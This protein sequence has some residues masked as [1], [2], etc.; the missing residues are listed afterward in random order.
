M[1]IL[2]EDTISTE[3]SARR[4]SALSS[5]FTL[6]DHIDNLTVCE[7]ISSVSTAEQLALLNDAPNVR[8]AEENHSTTLYGFESYNYFN[9]QWAFH[10]T[11]SYTYYINNLPIERTS[12]ADIDINLPEAYEALSGLDA[13]RSVTVAVIDTGV[14][15]TH[16]ALA[17]HI[18]TN[19]DEIPLNGIDDDANGYIDDIYGWDFYHNDN[20][21]CHYYV[22]DLGQIGALPEDNDNHG[23]HCAGIIAASQDIFGVA[24]GI[25]IRI[26][27]LKIHGGANASGS[28]SAAIKAIKYAETAGADICNM[29]W[30]TPLYSE[31]LETV[32]RESDMLFV[33]AAGNYGNNNN[34][35]PLYPSSFTL[36]NMISVAFVTQSGT[37]A[38]DS[39]Y[40][41]STVDI[42]APGQDIYSTTV[43]GLYH[44]LSG[45][46]MAAPVV[47]GTA[48]LLYAC[49]DS[50]YPQNVKEII[51]QT[52]KPL[53]SLNGYVRYPG[54]PDAAAALAA[55]DSLVS[56]TTAPTLQPVTSHAEESILVDLYPED[57]GGSG[58]RLISY[59][60]DIRDVSYFAKGTVGQTLSKSVLQLGKA[61]TY[62]FYVSDYAGNETTL[63]Y[64]V[65][66]DK[67]AP[68][69]S[70]SYVVNPDG[71]FTVTVTGTDTQSGVKRIRYMKG[72]HDTTAFLSAGFELS[73]L[74][75][76]SFTVI[77]ESIYTFYAVDYRG[78]KTVYT[79]DVRKVPAEQLFLSTTER[80][81]TVGDS[82]RLAVLLLPLTTT[83][84]LAFAV[85]DE[86]LLYADADGTLTALAPGTVDVTVTAVGG[87]SKTCRFHILPN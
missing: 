6:I 58:V 52:L 79:L 20:T 63:V 49:G 37:L 84:T 64:T 83:D 51:I 62:T 45:S 61:G 25:D 40:G 57:L 27:P 11:G 59:A 50:L 13:T 33:V 54:I 43:G 4:L 44:Y 21:V 12:K 72:E 34:A 31:A 24:A 82:Y 85:S 18:W 73:P 26:L 2:W 1:I 67:T 15:I 77:E 41:V 9:A 80:T 39:N 17:E 53:D 71:T 75:S 14:D 7:S 28:V 69:L 36:D 35:T 78:N 10:N 74:S 22:S 23:T 65:E 60:T 76:Y 47:S 19:E 66:D 55:A 87:I 86:T 68:S 16:P 30:G 8:V 5:D 29:S 56:D 48:A 3:E 70:A 32:M 38:S 42:A 81:M 46:S